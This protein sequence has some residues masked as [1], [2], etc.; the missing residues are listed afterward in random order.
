MKRDV[1]QMRPFIQAPSMSSGQPVFEC[2]TRNIDEVAIGGQKDQIV[3]PRDGGNENVEG[4][5]GTTF[6]A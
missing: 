6:Q 2:Q 1:R 5:Y 3:G 4:R